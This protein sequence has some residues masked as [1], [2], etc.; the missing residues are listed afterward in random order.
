MTL[1]KHPHTLRYSKLGLCQS[2]PK[3]IRSFK[4]FQVRLTSIIS[5]VPKEFYEFSYEVPYFV[6]DKPKER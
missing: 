3:F 1:A 2:F 6:C 5:K 4:I